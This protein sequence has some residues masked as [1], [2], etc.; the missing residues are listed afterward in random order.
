MNN[1][2]IICN[3]LEFIGIIEI[4]LIDAAH[5]LYCLIGSGMRS[6]VDL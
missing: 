5:L 6:Y 4:M 2:K 3:G 1:V